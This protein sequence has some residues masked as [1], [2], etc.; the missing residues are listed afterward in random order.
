LPLGLKENGL[1][2]NK[3]TSVGSYSSKRQLRSILCKQ[4]SYIFF[5]L[6]G[7]PKL[8]KNRNSKLISVDE[9]GEDDLKFEECFQFIDNAL[10]SIDSASNTGIVQGENSC[11][12]LE[13]SE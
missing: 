4:N 11:S 2:S 3:Y 6:W 7:N 8:N 9:N 10:L 13:R 12:L 5:S 1:V